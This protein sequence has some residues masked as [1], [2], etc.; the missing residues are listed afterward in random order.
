[1]KQLYKVFA[2]GIFELLLLT[3][4]FFILGYGITVIISPSMEP[5]LLTNALVVTHKTPINE[6]KAGDIIQYKSP[7]YGQVMHRVL[8]IKHD[9]NKILAFQ[10]KGDN[11]DFYDIFVA[12]PQN[13][14]A[15]V[16]WYSNSLAPIITKIFGGFIT[17]NYVRVIAGMIVIGLMMILVLGTVTGCIYKIIKYTLKGVKRYDNREFTKRCL[18]DDRA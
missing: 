12:T 14:R 6:V 13:Y 16:V 9:E 5:K 4:I 10:T 2:V 11:N 7:E 3:C 17:I 15:E 18:Y 1:M 8:L